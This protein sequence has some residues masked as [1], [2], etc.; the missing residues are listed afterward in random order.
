MAHARARDRG[1][2]VIVNRPFRQKALNRRF[3]GEALP[4]WRTR[5]EPLS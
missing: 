4:D 2:A 3:E 5:S 1:I